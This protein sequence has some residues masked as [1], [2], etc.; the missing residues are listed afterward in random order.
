ML[1]KQCM[2]AYRKQYPKDNCF[3]EESLGDIVIENVRKRKV[4]SAPPDETNEKFIE[5]LNL[6]KLLKRNLFYEEWIPFEYS[7]DCD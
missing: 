2:T 1:S 5:R 7:D 3:F 6:S 4:F